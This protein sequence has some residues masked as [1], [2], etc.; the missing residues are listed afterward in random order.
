MA[1]AGE[2][3]GQETS[4]KRF[5]N[6]QRFAW[7]D[8]LIGFK[9]ATLLLIGSH[10]NGP[11]SRGKLRVR[12][13]EQKWPLR[14]VIRSRIDCGSRFRCLRVH[15]RYAPIQIAGPFFDLARFQITFLQAVQCDFVS[16]SCFAGLACLI[17]TVGQAFVEFEF[18]I[19]GISGL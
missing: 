9:E 16:A 7:L 13:V 10:R 12:S 1:V 5:L 2:F 3:F 15:F 18:L 19:V 11:R 8:F 4:G 17:V 14:I 6:D